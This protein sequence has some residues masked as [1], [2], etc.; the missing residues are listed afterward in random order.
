M[1]VTSLAVIVINAAGITMRI[2][3]MNKKIAV[4][5]IDEL[6]H[7]MHCGQEI[8][9]EGRISFESAD[10][11]CS[12]L[13]DYQLKIQEYG[14]T[15]L[16]LYIS[17][18]L[19]EAFNL[20]F[21]VTQIRLKTGLKA[22]VLNN[23]KEHYLTLQAI[24]RKMPD[25]NEFIEKGTLILD[26]GYGNIQMTLYDHSELI[27]TQNNRLGVSRIRE[28]IMGLEVKRTDYPKL[29]TEAIKSDLDEYRRKI[30]G[31]MVIENFIVVGG[32]MAYLNQFEKKS[33]VAV[34]SKEEIQK[35]STSLFMGEHDLEVSEDHARL[36][37]PMF[38][39]LNGFINM[40]SA[41]CIYA[42]DVHLC[43]GAASDF[44]YKKLKIFSG[45]HFT[46]DRISTAIHLASRF[47]CDMAHN[48]YVRKVAKELFKAVS[49]PYGLSN[50]DQQVLELAA[51]LHNCGRYVNLHYE[52]ELSYAIVKESEFINLSDI[53]RL[54][55]ANVLRYKNGEFPHARDLN[56]PL[57]SSDFYV[58][59]ARVTA[60]FRLAEA[61]DDCHMQKL[62]DVRA[63]IK[64]GEFIVRASSRQEVLIEANSFEKSA[65]LF[66]EVFGLKPVFKCKRRV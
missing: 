64:D 60:I 20:D 45:H 46:E 6:V 35:L 54:L 47:G 37:A 14:I 8:Y 27:S 31:D 52:D 15:N 36:M 9:K 23:S 4:K 26:V 39:L 50:K 33:G 5:Q 51:I 32:E 57:V 10:E 41:S 66:Q 62:E 2:Y 28:T 42:P 65:G 53:N 30:V 21:L 56:E 29:I 34:Y 18:S 22:K 58:I 49:K 13:K 59:L 25:F 48:L 12:V 16:Q 1:A 63:V 3:E 7:H 61:L 44:A 19:T 11:I 24:A 17:H 43:D 38:V 40:T 55:V